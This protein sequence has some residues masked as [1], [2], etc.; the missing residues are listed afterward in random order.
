MTGDDVPENHVGCAFSLPGSHE[1][2]CGFQVPK[3]RHFNGIRSRL[4]KHLSYLAKNYVELSETQKKEVT[5][6]L[7]AL[8]EHDDVH[9]VYAGIK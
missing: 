3:S 9:R 5:D 1:P 7:T 2:G 6:F 8:D 4:P